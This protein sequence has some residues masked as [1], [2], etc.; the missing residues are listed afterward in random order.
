MNREKEVYI[1]EN[2][3]ITT[4]YN[5]LAVLQYNFGRVTLGNH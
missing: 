4:I 3:F 1:L 5:S 2:R